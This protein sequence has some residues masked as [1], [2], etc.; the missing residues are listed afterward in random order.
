ND[1]LLSELQLGKVEDISFR[2]KDGTEIH[3]MVVKPPSFEAGKKYPTVLWIHG[4][5][6]GQDDHALRFSLY[7]LQLERQFFAANGYVVLAVN[8]R[9]SNG[10]GSDFTRSI[11][12]DWGNKEVAD[13]LAGVDYAVQ[14]GY[15]DPERLGIGGW[16]YGGIL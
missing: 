4:G 5:P 11:F 3:G 16:S 12:A 15:A 7:P 13:L 9:G 2:S 1:A 6:N 10:R 14:Q 8:Y